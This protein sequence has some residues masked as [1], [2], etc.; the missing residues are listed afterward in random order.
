ML[1]YL[2]RHAEA[3]SP[4]MADFSRRLTEK[5]IR[6]AERVG[7]FLAERGLTCDLILTSPVLRA[8]ETAHIVWE[9]LG[10][11]ADLSEVSWLA[12]GMD[13]ETGMEELATYAK[14][15]SVMIVG[16]EPDFS[17]LIASLIGLGSSDSIAV[18]KASLTAVD[19]SRIASRS[20]ILR[21][22]LP[23]KLLK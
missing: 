21:F 9:K 13:P 5:G 16:H 1:L 8:K 23:V 10:R 17:A 19:L 2:L 12:C 22:F 7:E 4:S 20:G 14:F 6:Q 15:D 3:E 18:T 11:S